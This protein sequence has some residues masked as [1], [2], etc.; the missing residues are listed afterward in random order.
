MYTFGYVLHTRGEGWLSFPSP[1]GTLL[2]LQSQLQ[3]PAYFWQ[4]LTVLLGGTGT[5]SLPFPLSL[6]VFSLFGS[7]TWEAL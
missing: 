4:E 3:L 6:V 5:S 1:K 2:A 7:Q